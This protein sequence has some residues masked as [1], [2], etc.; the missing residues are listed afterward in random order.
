[1]REKPLSTIMRSAS[2]GGVST[3]RASIFGR[4]T[5][6]FFTGVSENSK[7]LWISS[8]SVWSRTPCSRPSLTRCLI[9]SSETKVRRPVSRMP[10]TKRTARVEALSTPMSGRDSRS[11]RRTGPLAS[12]AAPV[13]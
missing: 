6:T 1:M 7:T 4:G 3:S 8:I 12:M 9:S 10:K 11:R 5:M 2:P 13:L